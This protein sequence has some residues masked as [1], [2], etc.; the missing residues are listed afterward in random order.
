[1]LQKP[2]F[3]AIRALAFALAGL[4]GSSIAL[5]GPG[6]AP[7][8]YDLKNVE[9]HVTVHPES[10]TLDG[11]VINSIH[12]LKKEAS[13]DFDAGQ[14]TIASVKVNGAAATNS[15]KGETLTVQ[16]PDGGAKGDY[17]VDIVYNCKPTGGAYF[18][19]GTACYPGHTP[20]VFTQG[21]CE[22]NRYW[23]PT[24]DYPDNKA[25]SEGFITV[26]K[27]WK[28]LSNGKLVA[29]YVKGDQETWHWKMDQPHS[30]YLISFV[31]GPYDIG[32]EMW[33][34][35]PVEYWV[36]EG[37][38][39]WGKAAFGGT[40]DIIEVYSKLTGFKYP[41]AKFAQS[42]V[43]DFMFGG[44]E[45]ITCVT[46][47]I[48]ALFPPSESGTR[49]S[50]GLVAHELAHQWFGDTVTCEDWSHAWLNEGF[51][52]FMPPFFTRATK[53][54]EAFQNE[55][56]GIFQGA[57]PFGEALPIVWTGYKNP[58]DNFFVNLIY[59]GGATRMYMLM[60][61]LG[62]KV[63]WKG[64][65]DYLEA[66]KYKPVTTERFFAAMSKSS[67]KDL[68]PFM[69]Q[70]F[71]TAGI[72]QISAKVDGNSLVFSQKK[73][74]FVI[75]PEVWF[76]D[77]NAQGW[78]KKKLHFDADGS[79]FR[80]DVGADLA[81]A[82]Y[83]VDPEGH[84]LIHVNSSAPEAP[85]D[86]RLAIFKQL[87]AFSRGR[88]ANALRGIGQDNLVRLIAD[89]Q[90]DLYAPTFV[91]LL[92]ASSKDVLVR[93]AKSGKDRIRL[94]AVAALDGLYRENLPDDVKTLFQS[95]ADGEPNDSIKS[96]A[97]TA[98]LH[99]TKDSAL[100]EKAWS[101]NSV[102]DSFREEALQWWME[103]DKV[104]AR[105]HALEAIDKQMSEP[106]VLSAIRILGEL[107]ELPGETVVYD[108][109]LKVL[110]G[111]AWSQRM[112]AMQALVSL[113]NKDALPIIDAMRHETLWM[114]KQA[115]EGA[116]QQLKSQK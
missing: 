2:R 105:K 79:D 18:V 26:P 107:K 13:V 20:V 77:A 63:F 101:R 33:G 67:G 61:Q 116:Y 44:M 102:G 22:D 94:A 24:Y 74:Y 111:T 29:D 95:L 88:F 49:N 6:R 41:Y 31:A 65:H 3:I 45:N 59:P 64:I 38:L 98:I 4:V 46:Q 82:Y 113:G 23:L 97:F 96:V 40:G 57:V 11:E 66:N 75:D 37:L 100:V 27:G 56:A 51:A 62:E 68:T 5:A 69:K 15:L 34:K 112:S 54:E 9:W 114:T 21:E 43:P 73:P 110:S 109:M 17:K 48:S 10:A 39:D 52:T 87:P 92:D 106:V 103:H 58:F 80:L 108:H 70:W 76:W 90:Y 86:Q 91:R 83:R 32:H 12:L 84:Y 42:A 93:L 16:L 85:A 36:P 28:V 30:T 55:R 50:T 7:K 25:S 99:L 19:P 8:T 104:A 78:V 81:K 47:T 115:A 35:M 14:L 89:P 53:G 60:D 72:P 1:M 71:Y